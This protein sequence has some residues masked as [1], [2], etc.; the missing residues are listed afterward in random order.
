MSADIRVGAGGAST[1]GA[2]RKPLE[3]GD[4]TVAKVAKSVPKRRVLENS[5]QEEVLSLLNRGVSKS[6]YRNREEAFSLFKKALEIDPTNAD[7]LSYIALLKTNYSLGENPK[8][9]VESAL[10]HNPRSLTARNAHA[11]LVAREDLEAGVK[12]FS[13]ILSENPH[14]VGAVIHGSKALIKLNRLSEAHEI[15]SKF[16]SQ[17]PHMSRVHLVL[18][19]LYFTAGLPELA[20]RHFGYILAQEPNYFLALEARGA[21]YFTMGKFEEAICDYDRA[22][23]LCRPNP[24]T[25][26]ERVHAIMSLKSYERYPEILEDLQFLEKLEPNNLNIKNR[27]LEVKS[28]IEKLSDN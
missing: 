10:L 11:Y 4:P 16:L 28:Q 18:G 26:V 7:V 25:L 9:D 2:K 27:L 3:S 14:S 1:A 13:A 22:I 19:E 5:K 20:L 12:E 24:K 8:A 21:L 17:W 23:C 15:L 6:F